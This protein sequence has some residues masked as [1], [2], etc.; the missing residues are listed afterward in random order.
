MEAAKKDIG[1]RYWDTG[2]WDIGYWDIG[3]FANFPKERR[4]YQIPDI[5]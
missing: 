2:Y 5:Q 4:Q 3:Y 1:K